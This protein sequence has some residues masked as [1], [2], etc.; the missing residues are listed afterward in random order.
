VSK[1][2]SELLHLATKANRLASRLNGTSE[3]RRLA[4]RLARD[5]NDLDALSRST[6]YEAKSE[7]ILAESLKTGTGLLLLHFA[8]QRVSNV[9]WENLW[10]GAHPDRF[11]QAWEGEDVQLM[12]VWREKIRTMIKECHQEWILA[13]GDAD[14]YIGKLLEAGSSKEVAEELAD[15]LGDVRSA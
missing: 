13:V 1:S 15:W 8:M 7:G 11:G 4:G 9:E 12:S 6:L 5:P 2:N 10:N 3:V 14:E